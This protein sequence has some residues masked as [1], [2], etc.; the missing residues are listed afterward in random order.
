MLLM[1]QPL[2]HPQFDSEQVWGRKAEK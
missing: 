2:K 1:S